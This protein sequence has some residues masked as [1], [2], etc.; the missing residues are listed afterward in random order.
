MYISPL[1]SESDVSFLL[2]QFKFSEREEAERNI[3]TQ[4]ESFRG[5]KGRY[6]ASVGGSSSIGKSR[7][8]QADDEL[9]EDITAYLNEE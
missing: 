7:D 8:L 1:L 9:V 4:R 5:N 3:Y 6:S 2:E